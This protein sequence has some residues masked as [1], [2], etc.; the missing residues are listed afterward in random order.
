MPYITRSTRVPTAAE[1]L[2]AWAYL[3]NL[4]KGPQF[5]NQFTFKGVKK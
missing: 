4:L 3:Y 5:N 2:A 1:R